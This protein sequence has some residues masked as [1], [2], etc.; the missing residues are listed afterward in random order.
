MNGEKQSKAANNPASS[1]WSAW[2]LW[3][4]TLIG[5][6]GAGTVIAALS[7]ARQFAFSWLVAFMFFLSIVLGSLFLTLMHHL[8]DAAWSTPIR[9]VLE[10]LACLAFPTMTVLF[11]PIAL[12]RPQL[13]AGLSPDSTGGLS[14]STFWW[15]SGGCLAIWGFLSLRLRRLSLG[16]D[17]TGDAAITWSMRRYSIV[18]VFLFAITLTLAA[19]VWM[20]AL[21]AQWHSTIYGVWYFAACMWITCPTVYVVAALLARSGPLK[22]VFREEQRYY[23]GTLSLAFTIF[24]AYIAYS[25]FFIVWNG[26]LPNETFWY[27]ARQGGG[28]ATLGW[29]IILGHFVV[30]FLL[31]LRIDWKLR[32]KLMLPLC[33]V[34][35]VVHFCD[36]QFQIMPAIQ[37]AGPQRLW[38]NVAC[39]LFVAGILSLAFRRSYIAHAPYPMRDPR[40][41]ESLGLHLPPT[42][43]IATAPQRAK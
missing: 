14:S 30:P 26:N 19:S 35:W 29:I 21:A 25:Q 6:G 7:D 38:A 1:D 4:W 23:L 40:L 43:D 27:I 5:V 36:L 11:V 8:F 17:K 24:Y 32:L 42:T 28:W 34:M 31:L 9:R 33:L 3:S 37:P 16:Q 18:G 2:R 41:A 13:Y 12:L 20:E 22:S 39:L 15:V 10:H